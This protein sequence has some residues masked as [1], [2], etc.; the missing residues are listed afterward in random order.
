MIRARPQ[1]KGSGPPHWF[2]TPP[3]P[4]P[5]RRTSRASRHSSSQGDSCVAYGSVRRRSRPNRSCPPRC[6]P[7]S[8]RHGQFAMTRWQFTR[9]ELLVL[10]LLPLENVAHSRFPTNLLVRYT[11]LTC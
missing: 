3:L 5:W 10:G 8:V 9:S 11:F 1:S 6:S 4:P 7:R 2:L